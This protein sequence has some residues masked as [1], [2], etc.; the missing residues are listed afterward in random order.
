MNPIELP[1]WPPNWPEIQASIVESLT[2]GTWGRYRG[3]RVGALRERLMALC[4]SAH[5]RPVSSGS[6]GVELA[7]RSVG[8]GPGTSVALCGYDYPGNFRAVELLGGR[9]VLIDAA[10]DAFSLA[11]DQLSEISAINPFDAPP[12]HS[13]IVSHLYGSP[14]SIRSIREIC[15][16]RGWKLI[17][18]AC[19]VPGMMVDGKPA[20]SWG[21][22]GVLSFGGSKPLSAGCGGALLSNDD[23]LAA[24][25]KSLL[26]RPVTEL[27]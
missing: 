26:D 5:V 27:E 10:E 23:L 25:W 18:D 24:K 13:V 6:L 15:D 22:V 8:V 9:P 16:R 2:D 4:Q 3:P 17:E 19:Q 12:I 11:A 1:C 21:D 20:G 14:A 7:L